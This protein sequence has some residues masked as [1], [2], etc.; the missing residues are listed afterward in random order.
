MRRSALSAPIPALLALLSTGC[1]V[2]PP[3][4]A[5]VP[6]YIPDELLACPPEPPR[7][8]ANDQ[9]TAKWVIEGFEAGRDCRDKLGRV[10]ALVDRP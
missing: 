3:P 5:L 4:P 9:A 8:A 6:Q 2:P 1:T 10:K 7:P